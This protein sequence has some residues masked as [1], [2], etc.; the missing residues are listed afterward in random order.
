M[1][2]VR[3]IGVPSDREIAALANRYVWSADT[4]TYSFPSFD[5]TWSSDTSLGYG[6]NLGAGEPWHAFKPLG[7]AGQSAFRQILGSW[8]AISQL[9]FTE[10]PESD[11]NWGIIRV[12]MT[13][14]S[15][16][17]GESAW[18]YFPSQS[19]RGGDVWLN[20]ASS[21]VGSGFERG[22]FA[23]Y[24]LMHELGHALGLT[25]PFAGDIKLPTPLDSLSATIM[26]YDA[27]SGVSHSTFNYYP[28]TP[29]RL[30]I[31]AIQYL[32]GA[33]SGA[34]LGSDTY[35]FDDSTYYHETIWDAGGS[36]TIN[37][38]GTQDAIVDLRPGHGSYIGK[39][40]VALDTD[41]KTISRVQNI[42]LSG[43]TQIEKIITGSGNDMITAGP[44][45]DQIDGGAGLDTAVIDS[46]SQEFKIARD[47][48]QW[49]IEDASTSKTQL[50][51]TNLERV[52]FSDT[53]W[54][55]D[56]APSQ[57]TGQALLAIRALAP[58]Y[59]DD[60]VTIG[61]VIHKLDAGLSLSALFDQ[62]LADGTVRNLIG[63]D[64]SRDLAQVVG[65]NV[66]GFS[67]YDALVDELTSWMS[68]T[69]GQLS[70]TD[71]L[72]TAATHQLN[73]SAISKLVGSSGVA[74]DQWNL[75]V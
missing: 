49:L 19:E 6:S 27:W 60:P 73:E 3:A 28:T 39:E 75:T 64:T 5:S 11:T 17:P 52:S 58:S 13:D 44:E 62:L 25:H 74:Y 48:N 55:L 43:D 37:Y 54:A 51:L 45:T 15:T 67:A 12:G 63:S 36:D 47:A 26:S 46:P 21:L 20:T 32:Y 1:T 70:Q 57:V 59:L 10:V 14:R 40:I 23:Y 30:D 38:S 31:E 69:G 18:A 29:M 50:R 7:L 22:T 8:S 61:W 34:A 56:V 72:V 41:G 9:N 42:W 53:N 71:F 24:A 33:K 65:S 16:N 66:I 35:L 2:S 4:I 68:P